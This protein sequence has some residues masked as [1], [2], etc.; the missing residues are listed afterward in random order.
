MGFSALTRAKTEENNGF[1]T[2]L[3]YVFAARRTVGHL[4]NA[5]RRA[6]PHRGR[7]LRRDRCQQSPSR[8]SPAPRRPSSASP[9]TQRENSRFRGQQS[10][11]FPARS[12]PNGQG[13]GYLPIGGGILFSWAC[14]AI[15][16]L[17]VHLGSRSA[18]KATATVE[19][20]VYPRGGQ[21]EFWWTPN[22]ERA[23]LD[24]R[25][26]AYLDPIVTSRTSWSSRSG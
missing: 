1:R 8:T 20:Y 16:G 22:P 2:P 25:F 9:A 17:I 3:P 14:S 24:Q 4:R 18:G 5:A 23:N 7:R 21:V 10:C 13:I 19:E 15:I 6:C 11:S 12:P 26:F